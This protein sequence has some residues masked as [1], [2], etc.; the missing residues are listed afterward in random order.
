MSDFLADFVPIEQ[1]AKNVRLHEAELSHSRRATRSL[2]RT[3]LLYNKKGRPG[4]LA[5]GRSCFYANFVLRD[6]NDPFIPGTD[7]P[8]LRLLQLAAN[9]TAAFDN[10]IDAVIEGLRKWRDAGCAVRAKE[11]DGE[12]SRKSSSLPTSRLIQS[13]C[14]V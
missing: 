1:F 7:V 14:R 3:N 4:R 8:R 11:G 13:D 9:A 10:E 2:T 12:M 5:I 6:E